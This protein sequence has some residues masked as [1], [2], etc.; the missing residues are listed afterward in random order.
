MLEAF[1]HFQSFARDEMKQPGHDM[2]AGHLFCSKL[3]CTNKIVMS[4]MPDNANML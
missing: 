3:Q 4:S 2:L 1:H